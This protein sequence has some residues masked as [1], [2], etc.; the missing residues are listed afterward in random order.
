MAYSAKHGACPEVIAQS[1]L[2]AGTVNGFQIADDL[3]LEY[4][5][6]V[7]GLVM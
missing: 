6:I 7:V 1:V 4:A 3:L 2:T 5:D